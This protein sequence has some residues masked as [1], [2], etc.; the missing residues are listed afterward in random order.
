MRRERTRRT[1]LGSTPAL[2]RHKSLLC[3]AREAKALGSFDFLQQPKKADR[4]KGSNGL[5]KLLRIDGSPPLYFSFFS[6]SRS[7]SFE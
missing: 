7:L 4:S 3:F 6:P 1:C 5:Q 2:C